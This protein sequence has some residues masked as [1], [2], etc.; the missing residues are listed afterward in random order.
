M[1]DPKPEIA[2]SAHVPSFAE[3]QRLYRLSVDDPITFWR[4]QSERLTWFHPPQTIVDRDYEAID[5]S[6]YSGGRLNACFN[7]VDRHLGE[8]GDLTAIIWAQDEVGAYRHISYRELKHN[9]SRVAN[10]LLS[11][12]GPIVSDG[13]EQLRAFV[14]D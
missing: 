4:Q 8:R 10:V 3:Y 6:W 1:Y 9:V 11:H 12:G 5:F 13:R 14:A 2:K 7:C